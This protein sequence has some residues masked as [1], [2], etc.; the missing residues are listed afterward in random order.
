MRAAGA[1]EPDSPSQDIR[2][3]L[4]R[5]EDFSLCRAIERVH[6]EVAPR[7][8]RRPV[9]GERD[10]RLAAEGLD[11]DRGGRDFER[12]AFGHERDGAMLDTGRMHAETRRL[13]PPHHLLG[14]QRRREVDIGDR[15]AEQR[16][17]H[18]SA[19]DARLA[20]RLASARRS[21]L[22]Q[23]RLLEPVLTVPTASDWPALHAPRLAIQPVIE[24]LDHA[25]RR[26]PDIALAKGMA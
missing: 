17:A 16:I 12:P 8:I 26:A 19:G 5:I 14:R 3:T 10:A 13:A 20:A 23:R 15:L 11:I 22:L 9:V 24:I 18:R 6:G 4:Y 1:D 2:V 21:T 25:G 7:R